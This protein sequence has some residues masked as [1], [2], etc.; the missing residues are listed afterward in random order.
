M[1]RKR[2]A[3]A[4]QGGANQA[5]SGALKEGAVV[6]V[7]AAGV[8]ILEDEDSPEVSQVMIS[9][10]LPTI[11]DRQMYFSIMCDLLPQNRD[12]VPRILTEIESNA[13]PQLVENRG[14]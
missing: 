7:Q 14:I 11:F 10:R 3:G 9:N 4:G 1:K 6:A 2:P 8:S 5:A 12:K 13:L